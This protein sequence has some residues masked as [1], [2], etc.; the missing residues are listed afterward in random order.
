MRFGL[1]GNSLTGNSSTK[2]C[3]NHCGNCYTS[4]VEHFIRGHENLIHKE[5]FTQNLSKQ[6]VTWLCTCFNGITAIIRN[7]KRSLWLG[8]RSRRAEDSE[9][10]SLF[11]GKYK[12]ILEGTLLQNRVSVFRNKIQEQPAQKDLTRNFITPACMQLRVDAAL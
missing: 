2:T 5:K 4:R 9:R 7:Q 1:K 11:W 10:Y 8:K 3:P 12:R 6:F